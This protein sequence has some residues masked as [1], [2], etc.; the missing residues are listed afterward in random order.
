MLPRSHSHQLSGLF[1]NVEGYTP[2]PK[3][4]DK[5]EYDEEIKTL[6]T[7]ESWIPTFSS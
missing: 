6:I 7:G 1:D 4:T 3:T 2:P 5:P